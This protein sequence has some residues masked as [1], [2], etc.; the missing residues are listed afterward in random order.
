MIA[1]K[2]T[3]DAIEHHRVICPFSAV[4]KIMLQ[5]TTCSTKFGSIARKLREPLHDVLFVT[6]G[7]LPMPLSCSV[8]ARNGVSHDRR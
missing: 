1:K 7:R 6:S 3:A 5:N 4:I 2:L 8:K